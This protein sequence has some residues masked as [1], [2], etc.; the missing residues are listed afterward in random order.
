MEALPAKAATGN[1]GRAAGVVDDLAAV[2]VDLLP[3]LF[4]VDPFVKTIFRRN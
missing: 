3:V 4:E 1:P 2:T